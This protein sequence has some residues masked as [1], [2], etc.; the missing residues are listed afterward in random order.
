M[1]I[2]LITFLL[3]TNTLFA[4]DKLDQLKQSL[5][6]IVAAADGNVSVQV[7]SASKYD[8]LYSYNPGTKMIPRFNHKSCN[9]MYRS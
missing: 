8:L 9:G 4:N 5:D 1:K 6:A 2:L 7:V 3:F